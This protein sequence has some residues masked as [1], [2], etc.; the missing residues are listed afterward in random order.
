MAVNIR[1]AT[2]A[3]AEQVL[4]IYAPFCSESPISFET[5]APTTLEMRQRIA[6]TLKS[7]PWLVC[8][9]A[10]QILGYAYASRH[11]ERAAYR[12]AVDVSVYVREGSR[13]SGLGRALYTSLFTVLRLQGF[14]N[15]LAGTTLP[16]PGSEG[17]HRAM[18][19]RPV[20]VYRAIGYKCGAWHDVTWWQLALQDSSEEPSEP[21]VLETVRHS[22]EWDTA[23]A[24]G[25]MLIR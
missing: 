18:G 22:P 5:Q 2:P 7:L 21:R 1:L 9:D 14:K 19:F 16:N 6:K 17:L 20:G 13:R 11:R 8:D 23:L 25:T 24:A 15:A 4:T 12:W 3:D 10:G